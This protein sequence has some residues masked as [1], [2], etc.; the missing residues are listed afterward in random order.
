MKKIANVPWVE[1]YRPDSF[2]NIVLSEHK[3]KIFSN[4]INKK[5]YFPNMIFWTSEQENY[6][7]NKYY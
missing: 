7:N 2:D 3:K 1:K 4:I 5:T 6:D